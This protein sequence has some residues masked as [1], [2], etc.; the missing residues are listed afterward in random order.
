M[1]KTFPYAQLQCLIRMWFSEHRNP[2]IYH[3]ELDSTAMHSSTICRNP[4]CRFP[5]NPQ[6]MCACTS[7][8]LSL[9][10]IWNSFF[11]CQSLR[12]TWHPAI[13]RDREV[14][15]GRDGQIHHFYS[16]VSLSMSKIAHNNK[17]STQKLAVKPAFP[18]TVLLLWLNFGAFQCFLKDI[19]ADSFFVSFEIHN[20]L[21]VVNMNFNF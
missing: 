11:L 14:N 20:R 19:F 8:S 9:N 15:E 5:Q 13:H 3:E 17:I 1:N 18:E 21:E 4:Y 12:G 7:S 2:T 16:L 6:I 10:N